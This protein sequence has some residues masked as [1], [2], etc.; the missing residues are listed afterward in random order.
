MTRNPVAKSLRSPHLR[1]KVHEQRRADAWVPNCLITEDDSVLNPQLI[2]R[3]PNQV[4]DHQLG[5]KFCE[6]PWNEPGWT[7]TGSGVVACPFCNSDEGMTDEQA[8]D[9]SGSQSA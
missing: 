7:T 8:T 3:P 5:C 9:F 2:G 1:P 6:A 4:T